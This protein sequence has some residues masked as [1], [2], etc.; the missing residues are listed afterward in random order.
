MRLP[1]VLALPLPGVLAWGNL[2]HQ[3]IAH[4]ASTLIHPS[5]TTWAQTILNDTSEA[6][7]ATISTWADTYRRTAEGAFSA[8]FHYIDANDDPPRS[9]GVDFERDCLGEG[10]VVSAIA[11]YTR[12][13]MAADVL[14]AKEV[15]YALRWIVHFV[16]DI[17][18]PLHDE[19]VEIGGN[20]INV[21]FSGRKTNLH[22]SWDTAIP[23][24]LRGGYTLA[25][26][27][28][29]AENLTAELAPRGKF[30]RVKEGWVKGMNVDDPKETAMI[31][32]KDGNSFV[33]DTVIPEG[34]EGVEGEELFPAY[35]EG[36]V[37]VVEMQIA[38][39]GYRLAKWLD[40]IAESVE[41]KKGRKGV[42]K[43]GPGPKAPGK[44]KGLGPKRSV[45]ESVEEE[46]DLSG[47]D[48]LP[49][50]AGVRGLLSPAQRRRE[51]VLGSGD[52]YIPRLSTKTGVQ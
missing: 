9:C 2:G 14:D 4:L 12:R 52:L 43:D 3:T 29:W 47:R 33:C 31:W 32:A 36:V 45:E 13:V 26:A 25:D 48:L 17:T 11:N 41:G 27:K 46:W 23:E 34:V 28:A 42:K 49:E 22:A 50:G 15:D 5:T 1:L 24:Q 44:G 37:D 35:Y 8:P 18:Q 6:Y 40:G 39:G 30:G 7:L 21:T 10:C 16:G 38:K 51:A 19:A 20:G